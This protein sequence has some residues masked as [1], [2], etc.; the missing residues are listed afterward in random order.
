MFKFVYGK[1]WITKLFLGL[2]AFSFVIGTAIMWGPGGLNFGFGNYVIKVGDISIS[3]KE[4]ILEMN[5][6]KNSYPKL[7]REQL[8]NAA[9]NN[10]LLTSL[11]AYLAE[12]DGFYVS[13]EEIKTFIERNFS[14][15]GKFNPELFKRYLQMV[16]MTPKEFEESL[17]K[18]LLANKYK[19]AVYATSYVNEKVFET[20]VLPFSLKLKVKVDILSY[21]NFENLFKPTE[22][23][24]KEFYKKVEKNFLEEIPERVEIYLAKDQKELKELYKTLKEGKKV[25][26]K[27]LA[28]I[29]KE[30]LNKTEGEIRKLAE[31]VLRDKTVSV[32]KSKGGYLI[33]VYLPPSKRVPKFET[34]KDKVEEIYKQLKAVEYMEKHKGEILKAVKE[35]KYKLEWKEMELSAYELTEKFNLTVEDIFSLISGKRELNTVLP[36]GLAF[37][38]VLSLS[39]EKLQK[40][41]ADYFKMSVRN[42]D[43][44]RKL[45]EIVNYVVKHQEVQIE[46]NR[47]LL[48][49][50]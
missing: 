32:E 29:S 44:L 21:K 3:P 26:K 34:V 24:L 9:L 28:V 48:Q 17:R 25:S 39:E 42:A 19:R 31:R 43:Y 4:F 8:K 16:K 10:L 11:F 18:T 49:R 41:I 5:R 47:K 12:R 40:N 45:Q 37:I 50:F 15:E 38:R 36:Q 13:K 7:N 1:D 23:E 14:E 22:E 6:L 35:G 2:L 20:A 27:P 33:G 30:N 46:V